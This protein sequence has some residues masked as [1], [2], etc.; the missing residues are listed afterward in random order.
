MHAHTTSKTKYK[1]AKKHTDDDSQTDVCMCWSQR[2]PAVLL[3]AVEAT[4]RADF[5]LRLYNSLPH[6][7]QLITGRLDLQV[8]FRTVPQR[9]RV[10]RVNC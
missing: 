10:Q 7:A 3:A 1:Q 8:I 4:D 9:F 5:C 6:D 2:A